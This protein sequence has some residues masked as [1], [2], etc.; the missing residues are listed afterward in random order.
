MQSGMLGSTGQ[1]NQL[2]VEGFV[3]VSASL[4]RIAILIAACRVMRET[5]GGTRSLSSAAPHCMTR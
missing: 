2:S 5:Y 4:A 1:E 3:F